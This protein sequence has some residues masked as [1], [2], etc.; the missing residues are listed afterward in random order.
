MMVVCSA[1]DYR[2]HVRTMSLRR[3][4]VTPQFSVD[5]SECSQAGVRKE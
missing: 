5:I 3:M 4:V 1:S 2:V